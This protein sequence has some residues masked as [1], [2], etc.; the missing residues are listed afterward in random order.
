MIEDGF[1]KGGR[2]HGI[3]GRDRRRLAA[4]RLPELFG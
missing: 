2:E 4:H 3:A 1:R